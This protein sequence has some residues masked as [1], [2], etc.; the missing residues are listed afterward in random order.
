MRLLRCLAS[1]SIFSTFRDRWGM[2]TPMA[3]QLEQDCVGWDCEKT[4]RSREVDVPPAAMQLR[5]VDQTCTPT[6][7]R[8]RIKP[9]HIGEARLL[10]RPAVGSILLALSLLVPT[11]LHAQAQAPQQQ[12][13][14][15]ADDAKRAAILHE[16]GVRTDGVNVTLWTPAGV[17]DSAQA[18]KLVAKLDQIPTAMSR[19][20]FPFFV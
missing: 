17:L 18:A 5:P 10:W 13:N 9:E 12:L 6:I 19:C 14:W 2:R 8:I 20:S 4:G 7:G 16:L 1:G 15:S 3:R 11:S